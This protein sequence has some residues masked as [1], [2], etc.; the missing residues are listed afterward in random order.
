VSKPNDNGDPLEVI[1][2]LA[3]VT[4]GAWIRTATWGLGASARVA[5]VAI[6]PRTAGGLGRDVVDGLREYARAFLGITDVANQRQPAQLPA[7]VDADRPLP[8]LVALRLK[9]NELLRRSA[10]VEIDDRA[11]PAYARILEEIA[12]D[13]ARILRLLAL[14]GAQP[15]VD[16]RSS[17]LIG[18]GSQLIAEGLNMIGQQAGCR[19]PDRVA[20]YLNNLNRLGLIWFSKEAIEDPI[21]YQVLEAQPSVLDAVKS[22]SRAKTVQ[23]S[24]RLTPFGSDFVDVCLPVNAV[25]VDS[26]ANGG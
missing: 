11:H 3:R 24:V 9:G 6:D 19:Y 17:Q 14:E 12:P 25:T 2:G 4:A 7:D 15:A 26:P 23:R 20:P 16:V 8:E 13:E 1:G 21:S 10:D 18:L 22:A 5:R